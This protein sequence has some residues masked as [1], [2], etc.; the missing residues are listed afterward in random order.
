[1]TELT[2][3][4]IQLKGSLSVASFIFDDIMMATFKKGQSVEMYFR[5]FS[6]IVGSELQISKDEF[7]RSIS[8]LG[9]DWASNL[10]KVSEVYD[11]IS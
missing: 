7:I 9:V 11:S 8:T 10:G 2:A 6:R 1:M 4:K 3:T 5:S